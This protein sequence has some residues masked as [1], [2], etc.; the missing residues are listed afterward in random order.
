MWVDDVLHFWFQELQPAAWFSKDDE[1][2]AQIRARFGDL[3]QALML[4]RIDIPT[5]PHGLLAAIIVLDQFSR[6]LY[7]GSARAF[8]ADARA[9][10]L[11]RRSIELGFDRELQPL[12]RKFV[13]MPYMHSEDPQAQAECVRLFTELNDAESLKYAIEHREIIDRFGRFP[14]RNR[15]LGRTASAEEETFLKH[16]A[17]F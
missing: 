13:Y 3:H 15:T 6:N 14:H 4:E 2:D 16:H 9:L 5:T 12:E 7:R 17:G 8:A 1:L 10:G 11:A